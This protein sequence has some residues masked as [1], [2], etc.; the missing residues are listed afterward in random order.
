MQS[1]TNTNAR[2]RFVLSAVFR[3][4]LALA[5]VATIAAL[6]LSARSSAQSAN[7]KTFTSPGEAAL[8]LYTAVKPRGSQRE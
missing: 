8:A 3:P 1:A 5:L 7:E 6:M 2:L 4:C